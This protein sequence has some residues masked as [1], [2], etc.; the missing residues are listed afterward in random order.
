MRFN[1]SLY[2]LVFFGTI[3]ALT[4]IGCASTTKVHFKSAPITEDSQ[5]ISGFLY[6]PEGEG[7]FPAVIVLH[8]CGSVSEHHHDW[9]K[10]L[11]KWGYVAFVVDSFSARGVSNVCGKGYRV[12]SSE[13]ALDTAGAAKYLQQVHYVDRNNIGVIG[14]SHGG[15]TV[16]Q[17]VQQNFLY[18]AKMESFPFKAAVAFYPYCDPMVPQN[19]VIPTLILIGEKD[20]WTTADKCVDLNKWS[21]TFN[22][23][24]LVVYEG[25]YHGFDR[26][27]KT[28]TYLGHRLEYNHS[29]TKHA[30]A[31]TKEFFDHHLKGED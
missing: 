22:M 23:V 15:W 26:S 6:K 1:R 31:R 4:L 17:A 3:F 5:Q 25:A 13:R 8:G 11:V 19:I 18:V 20:D 27:K 7:T 16:L 28:R 12:S 24:E 29:A 21:D 10:L 2:L 30:K 14:F 9:A